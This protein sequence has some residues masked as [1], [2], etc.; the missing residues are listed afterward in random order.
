MHIPEFLI[1]R[2]SAGSGKTQTLAGEYLKLILSNRADFRNVLAITFTNKAAGEMKERV[3]ELLRLFSC[4][5]KLADYQKALLTEIASLSGVRDDTIRDRAAAIHSD[6]LHSYS[7][8]N[9]GTIDSF[10]HR[11]IRSFALELNLSF[12]FD[13]QLETD[14]FIR[15]AVDD[16]MEKA[17][18]DHELTRNLVH[19]TRLLLEDERS[20]DIGEALVQFARFLTAEVSMIPLEKLASVKIDLQQ[21]A[22]R[23]KTE[24]QKISGEWDQILKMAA[25]LIE[26]CGVDPDEFSHKKRGGIPGF[27]E[28]VLVDGNYHKIF[29]RNDDAK[30]MVGWMEEGKQFW[31]KSASSDV[32]NRLSDLAPALRQL[33]E[34]LTES[35]DKKWPEYISR[36]LINEN[37]PDLSLS[38]KI[39]DQMEITMDRENIIPIYEFNRLIWNIIRNQTAPFIYERTSERFDHF[40]I[41]EFQDTSS[42]QWM[43]LLPLIENSLS[44]GGMSM[45][46]GDAKQAIYRWRNG[47]V[48]QFVKLPQ[49][50]NPDNNPL[51]TSREEALRR[52]SR[53]Q[54]LQYN[55]RSYR[56]IVDFNNTFFSWLREK[57]PGML[58]DIY[59]DCSQMPG[60][61]AGEG[62]VEIHMIP[63]N[64]DF[65]AADYDDVMAEVTLQKV[66]SVIGENGY[67]TNLSDI[68][69]LVRKHK[70]A[71]IIATRLIEAGIEVVSSESFLLR[72]FPEAVY[73]RAVTGLMLNR[74]S[75]L[76]A[77]VLVTKLYQAGLITIVQMHELLSSFETDLK[78]KKSLYNAVDRIFE[79]A[80]IQRSIE[81]Y[82][83]MPLY[84]VCEQVMRDF[85]R[86]N[87]I[88]PAV[89][90]LLDIT[91]SFVQ[92]SG[93]DLA[94]FVYYLDEKLDTSV[95]L[96][97]T[98]RAIQIMTIHKAKGLQFPV[99]IYAFAADSSDNYNNR[100]KRLWVDN[101]NPDQYH[102]LPVLLLPFRSTL[103]D[104]P[105]AE[106]Y[107]KEKN[108]QFQ[109]LANVV[110]VALTRAERELYI[111]SSARNLKRNSENHL[112]SIF[113]GFI[114]ESDILT[115]EDQ[116]VY[117]YGVR[118]A[119]TEV[120]LQEEQ[121]PY[122][123]PCWNSYQWRDRLGIRSGHLRWVDNAQRRQAM[124]RGIVIHTILAEAVDNN[125]ISR[126][127]NEFVKKGLLSEEESIGVELDLIELMEM[128]ELKPFFDPELQSKTESTVIIPDG[129]ILRPDRVVM[130]PDGV[131]VVDFKTG[132]PHKTHE[133]QVLSY[134][135]VIRTMGFKNVHGYLLYVDKKEL[136]EVTV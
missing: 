8:F 41:D 126:L 19:F 71:S 92:S 40:L 4:R 85:F 48:W 110:Y 112:Y 28:R 105:F 122:R 39:R 106:F 27:F 46:V 104:T 45:V 70:E 80:G 18:E 119:G 130:I 42:L 116:V 91:A 49:L 34:E 37:L 72:T 129:R 50:H 13:V 120:Q 60:K 135:E 66:L 58:G 21:V 35:V 134:C 136:K 127:V 76:Q 38:R 128:E 24:M 88:V 101:P 124:H 84:E 107:E 132:A 29:H 133:K 82:L 118:A 6:I 65:K 44:Q 20:W 55:F 3:L 109:D 51:I 86:D 2:S 75:C 111:I 89:Q 74:A 96:P 69:I 64:E 23:N 11:I 22:Q 95:P 78:E 103:T 93:N 117:S 5:E 31:N 36:R 77:S 108:S 15:M 57:Y 97:E 33:W 17:G 94:A 123:L 114:E 67:R 16:L 81:D 90:Y 100:S 14:R 62:Y 125:D 56:E 73:L 10:V 12:A 61:K 30:N 32:V 54:N 87:A 1:Y 47:D 102:S 63:F 83:A 98:G 59:Q 131:A 25:A 68:C 115:T 79:T 43:N 99:V 53:K 121:L 7:E 26:N 9:I 113:T 52:Y